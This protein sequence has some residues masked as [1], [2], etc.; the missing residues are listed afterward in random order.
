MIAKT[1]T[2]EEREIET[3]LVS[4]E[5][6]TSMRTYLEASPSERREQLRQALVDLVKA[7]DAGRVIES[8]AQTCREVTGDL[9]DLRLEAR[10][11]CDR[12]QETDLTLAD[13]EGLRREVAKA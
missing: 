8:W 13:L 12:A 6:R 3:T 9:E 11:V 10:R 4:I 7:V 1:P 2:I 5:A